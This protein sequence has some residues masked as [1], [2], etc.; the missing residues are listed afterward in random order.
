MTAVLRP[1]LALDLGLAPVAALGCET[2]LLLS[3]DTSGSIDR[4][5]YRLQVQGLA[6]ALAD[7]DVAEA[8][9]RGQVALAVV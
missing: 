1:L 9:V 8:L 5:E 7:P 2:A 4:G 3:I 6:D